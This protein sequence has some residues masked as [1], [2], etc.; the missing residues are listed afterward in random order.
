M[1]RRN[2]LSDAVAGNTIGCIGKIKKVI[3]PNKPFKVE[4]M[5]DRFNEDFPF[6]GGRIYLKVSGK[7]TDG[8]LCIYDS[9]RMEK[10]GPR[11]HLHYEQD[12]W[13]YVT[14]GEFIIKV[15]DETFH[16]KEG[17][18]VFAPRKIPHQFAKV[19]EGEARLMF[20]L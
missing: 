2:F 19:S 8:D 11:L 4:A 3:R 6:L 7:D 15:G 16:A 5:K 18:S 20:D 17:D 1:K 14:K 10:G 13:F 9:V 12:E